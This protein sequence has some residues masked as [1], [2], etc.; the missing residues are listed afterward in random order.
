VV[1]VSEALTRMG[2]WVHAGAHFLVVCLV[3]CLVVQLMLGSPAF[4]VAQGFAGGHA[5]AEH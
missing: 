5:D 3:E 1:V 2:G 4:V